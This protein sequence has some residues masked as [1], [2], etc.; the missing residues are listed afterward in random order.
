VVIDRNDAQVSTRLQAQLLPRHDVG[1]MLEPG[2]D[3]LVVAIDVLPA[4]ALCHEIDRFGGATDE[5]D[6]LGRGCVQ[7]ATD[8]F[9]GHLIGVGRA[10]REFMG[11][12]MDVGVLVSVEIRQTVDD[13]LRLLRGGGVVEPD[14]RPAVHLPLEDGEIAPEGIHVEGRVPGPDI[15]FE[16]DRRSFRDL[17]AARQRPRLVEEVE[18][19]PGR[20]DRRGFHR[21][22]L[23][24]VRRQQSPKLAFAGQRDRLCPRLRQR[25][26]GE[27]GARGRWVG[28][29]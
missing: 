3:D 25:R 4:P 5:D 14:Q 11:A 1:V 17:H 26:R 13:R 24:D 22:R 27:V 29:R 28:K 21:L 23:S 9:P 10:G 12:A 15:G 18:G 16:G 8:L 19:R 20:D 7:Q 6:L 2:D